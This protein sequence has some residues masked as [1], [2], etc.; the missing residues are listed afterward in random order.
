MMKNLISLFAATITVLLLSINCFAGIVNLEK[1]QKV[2]VN[3]VKSLGKGEK[4]EL[5]SI[6]I[7]E[8][9]GI[10]YFYLAELSPKGYIVVSGDDNLPPIIAYSFENDADLQSEFTDFLKFDVKTRLSAV[11]KLPQEIIT[12]R[13]EMWS[14][15]LSDNHS[16]GTMLEQ[17]PPEGTTTTGGWLNSSWNQGAPWNAMCPIDP[18]TSGRSYTGCPATA[19]AMILNFHGSTNNTQ[20]TDD[21][22]Y[23]HNYAGRTFHI[24]DDYAANGFP[25]FPDLN[26]YLDTV[27][28][29]WQEHTGL[30]SNQDM[31]ALS[32]ACGVAATQ[33]FTSEGSGTF[34]VSQAYNAYLRFGCSTAILYYP[35]SSEL[36]PTLIQNMKDTLPAHLA[37]ENE[38]ANS[39]HNV[40]VDGYNT[41]NYFHVNFGWGGSYNGW[42]LIPDEMPYD[43]TVIEG[44]IVDI[45]KKPDTSP[46]TKISYSELS[47]FP[48]PAKTEITVS[49]PDNYLTGDCYIEICSIYGRKVYHSLTSS[50][51]N[52]IKTSE[53]GSAGTY[54]IKVTSVG[55]SKSI[56]SKFIIE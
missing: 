18:V 49:I 21:D 45:M 17:W 31:A 1:A 24:D 30:L 29:H 26:K 47:I 3:K 20:F 25:S 27:N 12:I 39:G 36:F 33:V 37:I 7:I 43:L 28:M 40:V 22:D 38:A 15:L 54:F 19:M 13:K 34:A 6:H 50:K 51:E 48:N 4:Y 9:T 11:D 14:N 10:V 44:I 23:Y 41:D 46:V 16:R 55:I 52:K 2:V 35:A 56:S 53:I 5:K 42:Y 8:E 32:F